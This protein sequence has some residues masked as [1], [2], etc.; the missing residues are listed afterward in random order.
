MFQKTTSPCGSENRTLVDR[1]IDQDYLDLVDG[2]W[3]KVTDYATELVATV[4]N[5]VLHPHSQNAMDWL[6]IA[7]AREQVAGRTDVPAGATL[8]ALEVASKIYPNFLSGE[9][10][11]TSL[12]FAGNGLK[13]W[14]DYYRSTNALYAPL[15][16]SAAQALVQQMQPGTPFRVLEVGAGSG[17]ATAAAHGA[18]GRIATSSVSY[19]VTDISARLLRSTAEKLNAIQSTTVEFAFERFDLNVKPT[20]KK[21]AAGEFDAILA[22][23]VLHNAQDLAVSLRNLTSL[24]KPGGALI[25]S[26]LIC[27]EK[28]QVHQEFFLNL[29]P[30]PEHRQ[31]AASRFF[32]AAEWRQVIERAGLDAD[33]GFN[34]SGPEL[35]LLATVFA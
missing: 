30:F 4:K 33:I 9:A 27:G 32:A 20:S 11:G 35:V 34:S 5:D 25:I 22:V 28:E 18:L 21:V 26:E 13:L 2:A 19:L 15:N 16:D 31:H 24:L 10:S 12:L 7:A 8:S 17:G 23:N 3:G 29:L 1:F 14:D 6:R